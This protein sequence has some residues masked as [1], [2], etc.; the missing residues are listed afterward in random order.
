MISDLEASI[1]F[2]T[3]IVGLQQI[4]RPDLGFPGA[5]FQLGE[6]QQL[7]ILLLDNI[8]PTTGRP[9]HGGQDRHVALTVDKFEQ[10]RQSLD[11]NNVIY[12]MSKSGRKALF[13]RDLDANAIEIIGRD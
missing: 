2:Y 10:V 9:E 3:E 7:H 8:D 11:R 5:W 1:K 13:F 6:N 4:E 12:S